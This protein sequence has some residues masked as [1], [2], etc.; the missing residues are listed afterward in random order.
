MKRSNEASAEGAS[1][2]ARRDGDS[3]K[4][5][6]KLTRQEK[7][8]FFQDELTSKKI[9]KK[10]VVRARKDNLNSKQPAHICI[11]LGKMA[12]DLARSGTPEHLDDL[13]A[14]LPFLIPTKPFP[15][16]NPVTLQTRAEE[17]LLFGEAA[18]WLSLSGVALQTH[19]HG[20]ITDT[21]ANISTVLDLLVYHAVSVLSPPSSSVSSSST[22]STELLA[23]KDISRMLEYFAIAGT[24]LQHSHFTRLAQ[25]ITTALALPKSGASIE[26]TLAKFMAKQQTSRRCEHFNSQNYWLHSPCGTPLTA[27]WFHRS[28]LAYNL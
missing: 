11:T 12:Y 20:D 3:K 23:S 4:K 19:L 7:K 5:R 22:Q 21:D 2:L 28:V 26:P 14:S 6:V 8:K 10:L 17:A 1:T 18:Y 13:V 24:G 16:R 27:L 25:A 15:L 9:E